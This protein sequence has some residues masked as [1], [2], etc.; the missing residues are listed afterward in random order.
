MNRNL[1]LENIDD[2]ILERL[3]FEAKKENMDIRA[4]VVAL[5]KKSLGLGKVSDKNIQYNDLDSL[6]GTW[7][8]ED[9]ND[10][11]TNTASFSQIESELWK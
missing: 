10:F 1:V 4:F 7:S 5:I 2:V 9:Y 8:Q 3:Q 6:A 11:I